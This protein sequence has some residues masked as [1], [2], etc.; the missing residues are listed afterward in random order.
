M[1]AESGS[2]GAFPDPAGSA[3]LNGNNVPIIFITYA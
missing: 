2:Y 3:A 1:V